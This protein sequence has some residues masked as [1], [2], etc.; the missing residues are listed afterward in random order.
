MTT[1]VEDKVMGRFSVDV[2]LANNNDRSI[3]DGGYIAPEK[4]RRMKVRGVVDSGAT[5]LVIPES[6][7]RQLGLKTAGTTKVRYA[8]GQTADRPIA[9]NIS[10]SFGG[11]ESVF[12]AV[13]E[14]SRQSALIGAIVMAVLDFVVDC[15]RQ[16][17][18]P[19][20]PDQIITEVE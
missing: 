20:D 16:Q 1:E 2:E 7:V 11:R 13:V 8:N 18:V 9:R 6:V 14:P 5:M 10:L 15:G 3:A 19:R 12:D 17:L 4:V